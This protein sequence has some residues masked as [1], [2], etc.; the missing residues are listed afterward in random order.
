ME[1]FD[2]TLALGD[3]FRNKAYDAQARIEF[4]LEVIR[5][6]KYGKKLDFTV[7]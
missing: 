5:S 6:E 7:R 4:A 1:T 2:F 3:K